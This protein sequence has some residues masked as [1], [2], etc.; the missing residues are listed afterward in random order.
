MSVPKAT[1]TPARRAFW[2][3]WRMRV[4]TSRALA[5]CAG[6]STPPAGGHFLDG[7]AGEDGRHEIGA[8]AAEEAQRFRVEVGAVLDGID[9]GAQRGVDAAG[10]VRVRGDLAAHG[11]GGLDDGA[12]FLVA[13]LLLDAGGG[14]G[15]HAAGG[16]DLDD[17]GAGLDLA[18]HGAAAVV[19]AGAGR[20]AAQHVDDRRARSRRRRRGRRQA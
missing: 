11:V 2:I 10:A 8:G 6:V 14:V 13:E 5:A 16:G 12:H 19:G 20:G 1:R 4:P 15:E 9:A 17:V 7:D 18:A 3:D